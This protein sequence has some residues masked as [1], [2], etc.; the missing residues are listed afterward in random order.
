M[1]PKLLIVDEAQLACMMVAVPPAALATV[2]GS[3][4]RVA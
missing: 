1:H 2:L 4:R 3:A